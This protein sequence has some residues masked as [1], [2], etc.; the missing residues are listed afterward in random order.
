MYIEGV[1][2]FCQDSSCNVENASI[3]ELENCHFDEEGPVHVGL[4]EISFNFGHK[5]QEK[6]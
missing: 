6:R 3:E 5:D 2:L 1:C 4:G